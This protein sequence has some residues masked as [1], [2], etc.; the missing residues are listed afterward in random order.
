M[1][2]DKQSET[3]R[4]N[5]KKS[6]GPVTDQGKANSAR[7][8][9]THNLTGEH[10]ALLSN[11]D[12]N[13]FAIHENEFLQ[14]FQPMDGVEYDLVQKLIIA[15][16]RERRIVAMEAALLEVEMARQDA[17][18]EQEFTGITSAARQGLA[19]SGAT[20]TAVA[21]GLL[22]RYASS[23]RR[24]FESSLRTL[25]L[26]QGDRFNRKPSTISRYVTP[27]A[28]SVDREPSAAPAPQTSGQQPNARAA[29][30]LPRA[31][32]VIVLRKGSDME[33]LASSA[34]NANLQN[35]P[36]TDPVAVAATAPKALRMA[37][38]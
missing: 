23:A 3:S 15:S 35:E 20:D 18:I 22:L 1:R 28:P 12:P 31:T 26:L 32:G 25:R 10:F 34:E 2:T 13:H 4:T 9:A 27:P 16:W 36:G 11:E 5:G 14:R 6:R 33:A 7:N 30:S 37:A 17:G 19:L 21:S 38:A 29:A 24:A 8:S